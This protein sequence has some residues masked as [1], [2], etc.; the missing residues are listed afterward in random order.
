V[1]TTVLKPNKNISASASM[2]MISGDGQRSIIHSSGANAVGAHCIMKLGTTAVIRSL[3]E[4]L[5]FIRN[6]E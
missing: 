4:T 5:L 2:V 1:D 3:K 6:Y